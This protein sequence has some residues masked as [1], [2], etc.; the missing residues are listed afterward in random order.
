MM[1][2]K[3]GKSMIT[4]KAELENKY[5]VP[6]FTKWEQVPGIYKTR[7]YFAEIG[8]IIPK[9]AKPDAVKGGGISSGRNMFFLFSVKKWLK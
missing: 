3:E 4:T 6:V 5:N 7:A 1:N 2:W 8:V 9:D